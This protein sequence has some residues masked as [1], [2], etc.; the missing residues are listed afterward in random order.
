MSVIAQRTLFLISQDINDRMKVKLYRY[1]YDRIF[2]IR[3]CLYIRE[4]RKHRKRR[5]SRYYLVRRM[6]SKGVVTLNYP[7]EYY[8][9][10]REKRARSEVFSEVN[11]HEDMLSSL[12]DPNVGPKLRRHLIRLV[13]AASK[14]TGQI[15][16]KGRE[17]SFVAAI[18]Y[19]ATKCNL[20]QL[21]VDYATAEVNKCSEVY[22]TQVAH[23]SDVPIVL[24]TGC[25][26]SV[27]PFEEDFCSELTQASEQEMCRLNSSVPI[28]GIGWVK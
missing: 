7:L 9:R 21:D 11:E 27:T 19:I 18:G 23:R 8:A 26:I 14:I 5:L 24:D 15:Y 10:Q 13:D 25:S 17:M 4:R 20:W 28:R 22:L 12:A 6:L 2:K 1:Y 16:V 3:V